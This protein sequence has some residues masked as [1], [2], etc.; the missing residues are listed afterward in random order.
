MVR[1]FFFSR[2]GDEL[3]NIERLFFYANCSIQDI[4]NMDAATF[5]FTNEKIQGV[6]QSDGKMK[7]VTQFP[8]HK[9]DQLVATF[10]Q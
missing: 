9:I 6:L 2:G 4:Y 3:A 10:T 5:T 8:I 7:Y 1:P